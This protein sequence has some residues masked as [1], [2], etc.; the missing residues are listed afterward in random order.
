MGSTR[1]MLNG[2]WING[3]MNYD[4]VAVERTKATLEKLEK[5]FA[6]KC[7]WENTDTCRMC[8]APESGKCPVIHVDVAA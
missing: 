7:A 3:V 8:L 2:Q 5:H 6:G 4:S 1:E